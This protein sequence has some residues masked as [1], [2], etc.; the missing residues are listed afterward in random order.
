MER[1]YDELKKVSNLF[2]I[3]LYGIEAH[4]T[5]D[6]PDTDTI[7]DTLTFVNTEFAKVMREIEKEMEKSKEKID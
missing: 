4:L 2:N 3:A 6:V 1:Y 7:V 5:N